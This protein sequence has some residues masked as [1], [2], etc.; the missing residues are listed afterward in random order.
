MFSDFTVGK[1]EISHTTFIYTHR[2]SKY[3]AFLFRQLVVKM[4]TST[5]LAAAPRADSRTGQELRGDRPSV[6]S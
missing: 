2:I 6:M 5:L 1:L 3:E 4:F